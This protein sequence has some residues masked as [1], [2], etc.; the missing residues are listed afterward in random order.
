MTAIQQLKQLQ[1]QIHVYLRN[2]C[3]VSAKGVHRTNLVISRD[4]R[5]LHNGAAL[6]SH[7]TAGVINV[8]WN[9]RNSQRNMP[10]GKNATKTDNN[11]YNKCCK[12]NKETDS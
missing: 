10:I 6:L 4:S 12:A 8:K 11:K 1:Q 7:E 5:L 3:D 2:I 9:N